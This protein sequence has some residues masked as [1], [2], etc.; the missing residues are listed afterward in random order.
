MQ[1]RLA[2]IMAADVVGYSRLVRADEIGALSRVRSMIDELL[3]PEVGKH[4]GRVFK[5]I[6]DGVLAEFPSVVEAIT[7]AAEIQREMEGRESSVADDRRLIL[8]IGVNLGDVIA[9]EGDIFGDGV[10]VASRLEALAEPGGVCISGAAFD[11]VEG[12]L[13]LAFE[14]IGRQSLKNMDRSIM[15]YRVVHRSPTSSDDPAAVQDRN[16]KPPNKPSIAVLPF[17]NMSRAPEDEFFAD[18]IAEDINTE[19]SRYD[20]LFVIARNST[21]G[22]DGARPDIARISAEL[23]VRHILTGSVRRAGRRV[24]ITARLIDAQ[25]GE[26]AWAD[27]Y[28]RDMSDIFEVQDE[29]TT[30]IVN[31]LF[32]K[33]AHKEFERSLHNRPETLDAYDHAL[34]ALVLLTDWDIEDNSRAR[35]EAQNAIALDPLF[36]RAYAFLG[37]T[38]S[39]EAILRWA[40]DPATAFRKGYEAALKAV[41]LDDAEPWAYAALGFSELWGRH[42]YN[43]GIAS[44]Q[45]AIALNPNNADFRVWLS[46]GLCLAGRSEEG[47]IEIETAMRLNPAHQPIYLHFLA[48]ILATMGRHADALGHLERVIRVMPNSTNSLALYASCNV[49]LGKMDEAREAIRKVRAIS[50]NFGLSTVPEA[51]PYARPEDLEAYLALL[52]QAGLPE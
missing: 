36:A 20:E 24:R 34:R 10:N 46:N 52:R 47:L 14:N 40:S 2:A 30:V 6:G 11:A 16:P 19:L 8:R 26:Q 4:G 31:T 41:E 5:L 1:R 44:L 35:E 51:S 50:P 18:G 3:R 39:L 27:R 43:R 32:G 48:R 12:K 33:I 45:R 21:V 38:Y 29:I 17:E 15:V 28:D 25:S 9:E 37:W 42:E 23:G 49:A 7:C 22:Y 13:D